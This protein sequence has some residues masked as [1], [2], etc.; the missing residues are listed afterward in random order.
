MVDRPREGLN[1]SPDRDEAG[2]PQLK[3]TLPDDAALGQFAETLA[4]LLIA[5]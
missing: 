2:R 5:K 4:R 1:E 3:I